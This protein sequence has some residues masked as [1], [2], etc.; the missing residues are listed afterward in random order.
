MDKEQRNK[1]IDELLER[2]DDAAM[3]ATAFCNLLPEDDDEA[4]SVICATID[5]YAARIHMKSS[6]VWDAFYLIS[7]QV[8][9]E[10]GEYGE[11]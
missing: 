6:D 7:K 11:I 1:K 8:H 2:L 4:A 9:K 5:K 10:F 3:L